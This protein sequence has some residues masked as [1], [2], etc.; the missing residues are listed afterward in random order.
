M[1]VDKKPKEF[2]TLALKYTQEAD[3]VSHLMG[4][5]CFNNYYLSKN[6][7]KILLK[8]L[9][10]TTEIELAPFLNPMGVYLSIDDQY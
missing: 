3:E 9:N 8:G 5:I 6:I 7:G 4:H 10:H 2:Y 1:M